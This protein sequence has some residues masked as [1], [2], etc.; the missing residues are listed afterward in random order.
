MLYQFA[1]AVGYVGVGM[2]QLAVLGHGGRRHLFATNLVVFDEWFRT[3]DSTVRGNGAVP[4]LPFREMW[5][6]DRPHRGLTYFTNTCNASEVSLQLKERYICKYMYTRKTKH[7]L[8]KR[9]TYWTFYNVHCCIRNTAQQI[10]RGQLIT[11][12]SVWDLFRSIPH[13]PS[14]KG[15]FK[16]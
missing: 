8:L 7:H 12:W 13:H 2:P 4:A 5:L 15:T 9:R 6:N 14:K 10:G 1:R 3:T 16:W 11:K